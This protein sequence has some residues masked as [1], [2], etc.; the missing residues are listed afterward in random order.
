MINA[1]SPLKSR[2]YRLLPGTSIV[3][4]MLD[5]IA[6]A[7][8]AIELDFP[9]WHC[10]Q[11]VAGLLYGRRLLSS[12]PRVVRAETLEELRDKIQGDSE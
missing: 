4:Y 3:V 12:P 10:W 7:L 11:G 5:R 1:R 2:D 6:G 9:C 8:E